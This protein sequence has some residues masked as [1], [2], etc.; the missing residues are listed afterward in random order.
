MIAVI[1]AY[2]TERVIGN[3][4][5]IPWKIPGE[6]K[7]FRQLSLGN[8]VIMG[9]K[10]YE[11][12]GHPLH[13]RINIVISNTVEFKGSN[14]YTAHSLSEAV[15]MF[16]E[17]DIYIAGGAMLYKEAIPISDVLYITEIHASFAGDT[18]FPKFN[19]DDY[20]KEESGHYEESI[21]YTYLTYIKRS[22]TEG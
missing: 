11:E 12:I 6:Q 7:R 14:L 3:K 2:T 1:A 19:P 21:P 15:S 16:P 9:R 8:V 22:S 4:G 10:T 13:D 18:F 5:R 17:K 20:I